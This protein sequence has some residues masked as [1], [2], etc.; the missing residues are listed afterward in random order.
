MRAAI[1]DRG[2]PRVGGDHATGPDPVFG[3]RHKGYPGS[4]DEPYLAVTAHG[5]V[6][7]ERAGSWMSHIFSWIS[8][9][10][11]FQRGEPSGLGP[12]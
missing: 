10:E 6:S 12:L 11:V 8:F 4:T 7:D 5:D 3:G 9:R 1:G 2:E